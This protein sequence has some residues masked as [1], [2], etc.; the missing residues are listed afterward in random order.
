M[1]FGQ[2]A[3]NTPNWAEAAT[4]ADQVLRNETTVGWEKMVL[5]FNKFKSVIAFETTPIEVY[6]Q[7]AIAESGTFSI[8][9]PD[10]NKLP[11]RLT[12]PII[13]SQKPHA[14]NITAYEFD[15]DE[16]L[17]NL[18]EFNFA[19]TLYWALSE[20]NAAEMAAKRTAMDNATNNARDMITRLTLTYNRGRQAAIT[21]DLC[22]IITGASAL[23]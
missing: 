8:F 19:N 12:P 16:I 14:A 6:S 17:P 7:K 4:I 2:V 21:N 18:A 5:Y 1:H 10:K 13:S 3:K 23:D 22:D 20:G 9:Q 15:S 11:S